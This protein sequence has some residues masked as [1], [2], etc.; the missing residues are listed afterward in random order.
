MCINCVT[1]DVFCMLQCTS[2]SIHAVRAL[3]YI[4]SWW[5]HQ[6]ET[7][8]AS[9]AICAGNSPIPGEFPAQRPVTRSFD[10]FFDLHPNKRLSKQWWGWWFE[11]P[12]SPLWRN[13]MVLLLFSNVIM[14]LFAGTNVGS[15]PVINARAI[16][17]SNRSFSHCYWR[18][19]GLI[20][21]NTKPGEHM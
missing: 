21:D 11:R 18:N 13:S 3:L 14:V 1:L 10:I 8:S 7:F 20:S 2:R 6:M 16:I 9:L 15:T 4:E 12:S 19:T 5:R 17:F